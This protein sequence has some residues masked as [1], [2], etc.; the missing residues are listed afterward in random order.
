MS[1]LS[2]IAKCEIL[3]EMDLLVVVGA[4]EET[5]HLSLPGF[6]QFGSIFIRYWCRHLPQKLRWRQDWILGPTLGDNQSIDDSGT[7]EDEG[8]EE[9]NITGK[10]EKEHAL[11][12]GAEGEPC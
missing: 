5:Y 2:Q 3:N 10:N 1:A 8:R 7:Q 12:A 4:H 9:S 11:E 6:D